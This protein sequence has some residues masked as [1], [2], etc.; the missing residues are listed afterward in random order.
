[1]GGG[2]Y[3]APLNKV[4][5]GYLALTL[6]DQTSLATIAWNHNSIILPTPCPYSY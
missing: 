4:A 3:S 6:D 2:R 1:M 5:I